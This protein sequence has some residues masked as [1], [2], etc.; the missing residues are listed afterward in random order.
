MNTRVALAALLA[1]ALTTR[2]SAE[3]E[4][5][6]NRGFHINLTT[7]VEVNPAR[8]YQ[9]LT[10][11]IGQWWNADHTYSGD[12]SNLS[13]DFERHCLLE[14]LPDNGFVRH[15]EIVFHQPGKTLRLTGG[16]G[17]LQGMGVGGAMTFSL[18]PEDNRTKVEFT[19]IVSGYVPAGLKEIAPA[20][21]R[22]LEEQLANFQRFC[23]SERKAPVLESDR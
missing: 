17:P 7:L 8:A 20:V 5:S 23:D 21:N 13:M 3:I 6:D 11:D 4:A 15:M 9:A 16:L 1:F 19:Y 10:E 14:K 12:A 22:V 2:A 18:S